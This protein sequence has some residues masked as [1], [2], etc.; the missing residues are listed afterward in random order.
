VFKEVFVGEIHVALIQP[1]I[2]WNTG[3]IGRTCL[4]IG[5]HLH[6]V[7][8]L[9]FVL[10]AYEIKRAG[11]DYWPHVKVHMHDDGH[12]F[13]KTLPNYER[14]LFLSTHAKQSLYD[15]RVQTND[16]VLLVFGRESA[17]LP[18]EMMQTYQ[19]WLFRIPMTSEHV[20]SLNIST[21]VA[22]SV[23]EIYRQMH[24]L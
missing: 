13:L 24:V 10:N 7:K 21:S 20:R 11:L 23:Y 22:I 9:G 19:S 3:N 15:T 16:K 12:A 1:E 4:A 6:L 17:G 18:E 14:V 8:P 2:P 5:A